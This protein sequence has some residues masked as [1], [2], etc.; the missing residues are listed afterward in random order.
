M[1]F[2]LWCITYLAMKSLN[3]RISDQLA[4]EIEAESQVRRVSKS[5]VVRDRLERAGSAMPLPPS[6]DD[7]A[8]LVGSVVDDLPPDLSARRK[9]YLREWGY[10]R[11][12][13]R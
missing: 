6:L 10:G 9:H 8:D 1:R 12:R 2:C 13:R 11:D 3:V 7:I 5:D 4:A